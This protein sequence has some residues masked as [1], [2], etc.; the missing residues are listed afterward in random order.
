[1]PASFV[2][3]WRDDAARKNAPRP[4]DPASLAVTTAADGGA[5]VELIQ[6]TPLAS[7]RA[8]LS[9]LYLIEAA[10]EHQLHVSLAGHP[11][12]GSPFQLTVLPGP[13]D[14]LATTARG[15]GLLQAR[16]GQVAAYLVTARDA[17]GNH[18]PHGGD[19]FA[20]QLRFGGSGADGDGDA[21]AATA[22]EIV[23]CEDGTYLGVFTLPASRR[24]PFPGGVVKLDILANDLPIQGSPFTIEVD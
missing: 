11:V 20:A 24:A 17:C 8:A 7:A 2:V 10:G 19:R 1:M 6:A 18:R 9:V 15:S 23:D 21:G 14:P 13:T 5:R 12:H 4:P 22:C 16:R 3:G